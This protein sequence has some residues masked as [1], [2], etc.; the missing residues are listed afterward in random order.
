[1]DA[2]HPMSMG[3]GGRHMGPVAVLAT[4]MA[5]LG[6]RRD[7]GPADGCV[8]GSGDYVWQGATTRWIG[9]RFTFIGVQ[10][11]TQK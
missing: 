9:I 11:R 7:A 1:V 3:P 2:D 8:G 10:A 4:G 6:G 5:G